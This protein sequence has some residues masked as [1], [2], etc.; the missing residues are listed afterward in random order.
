MHVKKMGVGVDFGNHHVYPG[1]EIGCRICGLSII[2]SNDLPVHDDNYKSFT[3]YEVAAEAFTKQIHYRPS[4]KDTRDPEEQRRDA[5]DIIA[6]I[7]LAKY[8]KEDPDV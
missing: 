3:S 1:D 5:Q 8:G 2:A 6:E 7:N 4:P